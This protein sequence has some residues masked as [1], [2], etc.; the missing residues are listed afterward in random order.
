MRVSEQRKWAGNWKVSGDRDWTVTL[1]E[2]GEFVK[3][4]TVQGLPA[5][6]MHTALEPPLPP[7]V[8]QAVLKD[9]LAG[10]HRKARHDLA[11]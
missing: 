4:A 5:A 1:S 10:R 8:C 3:C 6:A 7:N 11:R 9:S 2:E